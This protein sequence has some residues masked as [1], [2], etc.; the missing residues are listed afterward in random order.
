VLALSVKS[1]LPIASRSGM[2]TANPAFA[3]ERTAE[4]AAVADGVA[5][6]LAAACA[7]APLATTNPRIAPATE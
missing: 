3:N 7:S 1:A 4:P 2:G 5:D 6:A